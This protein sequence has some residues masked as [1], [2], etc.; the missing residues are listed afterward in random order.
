[1][2]TEYDK[3]ITFIVMQCLEI[4]LNNLIEMKVKYFN[5]YRYWNFKILPGQRK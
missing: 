3:N 1:M 2:I 5:S 4:S